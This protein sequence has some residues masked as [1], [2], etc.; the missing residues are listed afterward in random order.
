MFQIS[1]CVV[2]YEFQFK[3]VMI[4][5]RLVHSCSLLLSSNPDYFVLF[6]DLQME[7]I[8]FQGSNIWAYQTLVKGLLGKD[9][10]IY[11]LFLILLF[12][13]YK[14]IYGDVQKFSS[15]AQGS[16]T[17]KPY[18]FR[19]VVRKIIETNKYLMQRTSRYQKLARCCLIEAS[20]Q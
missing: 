6:L 11:F 8:S 16:L 19:L 14:F 20:L 12:F 2:C 17:V 9:F 7:M 1:S 13:R 4:I 15:F 18:N 10:L 3:L 5:F